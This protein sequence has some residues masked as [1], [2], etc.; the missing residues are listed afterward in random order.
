MISQER[1]TSPCH[2]VR[3]TADCL[4]AKQSYQSL[5]VTKQLSAMGALSF[6]GQHCQGQ[7]KMHP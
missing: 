6:Q 3:V 4:S 7:Y 1:Y 5:S 2:L